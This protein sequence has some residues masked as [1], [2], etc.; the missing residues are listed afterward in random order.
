MCGRSISRVRVTVKQS[1][2]SFT[3]TPV[4][5]SGDPSAPTGSLGST[6]EVPSAQGH[7][8]AAKGATGLLRLAAVQGVSRVVADTTL[9]NFASQKT[10]VRAGLRRVETD[11][12][13]HHLEVT[14]AP[15][16]PS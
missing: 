2:A 16:E 1:G 11:D 8:F 5:V 9:D 12:E 13:L 10:L 6:T 15:I 7:G 4:K 14:L 3:R